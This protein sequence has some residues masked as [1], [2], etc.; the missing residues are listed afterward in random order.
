[1][2]SQPHSG[3]PATQPRLRLHGGQGQQHHDPGSKAHSCHALLQYQVY[4]GADNID[5]SIFNYPGHYLI[6]DSATAGKNQ[7]FSWE[8]RTVAS[9]YPGWCYVPAEYFPCYPPPFPP[10]PPPAPPSPP[11][12]PQPPI[13]EH[14]WQCAKSCSSSYQ[15][16]RQ[17]TAPAQ[18][19]AVQCDAVQSSSG[20]CGWCDLAL[21]S[22]QAH[23][24]MGT[25]ASQSCPRCS[26][27]F[28]PYRTCKRPQHGADGIVCRLLN[29]A[30]VHMHAVASSCSLKLCPAGA[31]RTRVSGFIPAQL[32]SCLPGTQWLLL[33]SISASTP[34]P[35]ARKHM[36]TSV[37]NYS[38][39]LRKHAPMH[40]ASAVGQAP[41]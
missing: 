21:R 11:K 31:A 40:A 33:Q 30:G 16:Q 17:C 5:D 36:A 14:C 39:H 28:V 19:N 32:S 37:G 2:H 18:G 35:C 6:M 25:A 29:H 9:T 13:C 27:S 1:M 4:L 3:A 10:P 23:V 7:M 38:P 41:S 34:L 12:P 8:M 20:A 22:T 15:M 24:L 26:H